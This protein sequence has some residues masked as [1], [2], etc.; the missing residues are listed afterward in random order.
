MVISITYELPAVLPWAMLH[1]FFKQ[2]CR[3]FGFWEFWLWRHYFLWTFTRIWACLIINWNM[4]YVSFMAS[5]SVIEIQFQISVKKYIFLCTKLPKKIF[6]LLLLINRKL[7]ISYFRFTFVRLHQSRFSAI[8]TELFYIF[9]PILYTLINS[10]TKLAL[11][12]I[13]LS[14][15]ILAAF[16]NNTGPIYSLMCLLVNYAFVWLL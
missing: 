13:S 16:K 9:M 15:P 10:I 12:S 6:I 5:N 2:I 8:L 7:Q 1:L 14:A 4:E 3:H 11:L